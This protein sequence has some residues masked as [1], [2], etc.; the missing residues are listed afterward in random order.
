VKVRDNTWLD[1]VPFEGYQYPEGR[2]YTRTAWGRMYMREDYPEN[3]EQMEVYFRPLARWT[4]VMQNDFAARA[5]WCVESFEEA[6]HEPVVKLRHAQDLSAEPGSTV[7]L[8]ADG[9]FDPDGDE[10]TYRW[11]Y[12]KEAGTYKGEIE[13][14]KRSEPEAS[15]KIPEDIGIGTSVHIICEVSDRGVPTL[16]RYQR[17]IITIE[18]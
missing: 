2:W 10:L 11:W 7:Q 8:S 15:V 18:E 12:Y 3:Q 17:V 6:N 1:P 14:D 9:T 16:T 13:I 5:D 4:D